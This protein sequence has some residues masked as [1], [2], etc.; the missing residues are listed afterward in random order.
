MSPRSTKNTY[1]IPQWV[2]MY[3]QWDLLLEPEKIILERLKAQLPTMRMLDIG[4]GGGRT[5]CHFA[6]L[7]KEY[8]GIDFDANMIE[9]CRKRFGGFP[10]NVSFLEC[11]ARS[12]NIFQNGYFDFI[13]FSFNGLDYLSH[14]HRLKALR[15]IRR[16]VRGGGYFLF[17]SHNLRAVDRLFSCIS[18]L[19]VQFRTN[20]LKCLHQIYVSPASRRRLWTYLTLRCRNAHIREVSSKD[21]ATVYDGVYSESLKFFM[22]STWKHL[23]HYYY[24]KPEV[25]IEQLEEA[26]FKVVEAYASDTRFDA[27]RVNLTDELRTATENWLYYFCEIADRRVTSPTTVSV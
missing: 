22:L 17:S 3:S 13:L 18:D 10:K 26:G 14:E 24:I 8:V 6:G 27:R 25:Q 7:A 2:Q 16:V 11:D 21:Y 1:E 15:E 19:R 9:A 5:A 4:V 20:P 12:M 23:G